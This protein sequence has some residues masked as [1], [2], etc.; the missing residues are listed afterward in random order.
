MCYRYCGIGHEKPEICENRLPIYKIYERDHYINNYIYNI[1][2]Y[3]AR[4]R[5]RY[6]HDLIK[7]GNYINISWENKHKTLSQSYRYKKIIITTLAEKRFEKKK[8]AIL[9]FKGIII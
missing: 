9:S 1:L 2:I 6:L 3:K 8:T 7:Y 5:R 4:K